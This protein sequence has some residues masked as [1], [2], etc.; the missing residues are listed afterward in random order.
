M[1]IT[2]LILIFVAI[3]YLIAQSPTGDALVALPGRLTQG[4]QK[5]FPQAGGRSAG[6]PESPAEQ[7]FGRWI[8]SAAEVPDELRSWYLSLDDEEAHRFQ[9]SLEAHSRTTGFHVARLVDGTLNQRAELRKI[10]VE[11]VSIYSQAY[12]KARE[13]AEQDSESASVEANQRPEQESPKVEGKIV[14]EKRPS[15]RRAGVQ[16]EPAPAAG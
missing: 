13:A 2:I 4:V 7:D 9:K 3:G 11:A 1:T 16:S 10:Y 6:R 12:R 5:L 15:R 8:A 14:A